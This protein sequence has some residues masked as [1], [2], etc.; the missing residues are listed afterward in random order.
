MTAKVLRLRRPPAA[1][2][3]ELGCGC[4][5]CEPYVPSAPRFRDSVLV[6]VLALAAGIVAG[7]GIAALYD[8]LMPGLQVGIGAVFGS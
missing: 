3:H 1:D 5:T 6:V 2:I 4:P 8:R 7:A